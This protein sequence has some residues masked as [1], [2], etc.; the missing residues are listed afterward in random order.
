MQGQFEARSQKTRIQI[1]VKA[2]PN[3]NALELWHL[4]RF[5]DEH[6]LDYAEIDG[7]LTYWENKEHLKSLIIDDEPDLNR[8]RAEMERYTDY[9]REHFL[10]YYID[11]TR[12]GETRSKDVGPI[13]TGSGFSLA[14]YIRRQKT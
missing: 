7:T 4:K 8:W 12:R 2:V 9:R 5:C 13:S 6:G 11:A 14:A 10:Q 3:L 1:Q